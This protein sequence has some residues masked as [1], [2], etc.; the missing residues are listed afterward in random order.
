MGF[1][2]RDAVYRRVL[3]RNAVG[4]INPQ[5]L[6]LF[7]NTGVHTLDLTESMVGVTEGLNLTGSDV[8][9]GKINFMFLWKRW[10]YFC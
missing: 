6:G 8:L 7:R 10:I 1:R 2:T 5:T 4:H 3:P 9:K